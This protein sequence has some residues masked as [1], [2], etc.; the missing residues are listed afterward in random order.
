MIH[1]NIK[2]QEDETFETKNGVHGST[3]MRTA[4]ADEKTRSSID[5]QRPE[6]MRKG[7]SHE[8]AV[9]HHTLNKTIKE[10]IHTESKFMI[11]EI[12]ETTMGAQTSKTC[13]HWDVI[14]VWDSGKSPHDTCQNEHIEI[15]IDVA[16]RDLSAFGSTV[17]TAILQGTDRD[18]T[19]DD[20]RDADATN[21]DVQ[22]NLEL[23]SF[24]DA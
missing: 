16:R 9:A 4:G 1:S 19:R 13:V 20:Q 5:L 14:E 17:S 11:A 21:I 12:A 10:T 3:T 15:G 2:P 6:I 18:L 22:S 24:W 7:E 23:D 8:K